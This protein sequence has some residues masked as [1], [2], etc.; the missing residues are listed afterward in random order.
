MA[1]LPGFAVQP[2][3]VEAPPG[4]RAVSNVEDT[5]PP[6]QDLLATDP[7]AGGAAADR[8]RR[9]DERL[10]DLD[11][12]AVDRAENHLILTGAVTVP[13]LAECPHRRAQPQISPEPCPDL[14][15]EPFVFDPSAVVVVIAIF[16]ARSQLPAERQPAVLF[17][18][19]IFQPFPQSGPR[20]VV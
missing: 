9:L 2:Y 1:P 12:V 20:P 13:Q 18:R 3:G 8:T 7:K 14:A 11:A 17:D 15:V 4:V 16:D 6:E 10:M 19:N 5:S